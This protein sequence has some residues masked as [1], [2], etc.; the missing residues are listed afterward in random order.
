VPRFGIPLPLA[1]LILTP[2]VPALG[3]PADGP[4]D[5]R[6]DVLPILSDACFRCHGPDEGTRKAKLRLDTKDGLYRTL[7]GLTVVAPGSAAESEL[8]LR[9]KSHDEEEVMPPRD[10]M[11]QL[12]PAEISLLERWVTEGAPW[13]AHWAF[14]PL[15]AT[16]PTPA[17]TSTDSPIDTMVR[18]PLQREGLAP[19]PEADRERLLRRVTFDLTGLPP[20]PGRDRRFCP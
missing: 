7:H 20:T 17:A 8:V 16:P 3:A 12:K 4:V 19:A 1:L 11:R 13:S 18:R 10:S 2:I 15:A 6:R 9:I 14:T 5:F